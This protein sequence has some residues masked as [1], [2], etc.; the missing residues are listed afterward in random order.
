[1]RWPIF[2]VILGSCTHK[3]TKKLKGS[4]RNALFLEAT[5]SRTCFWSLVN[6]PGKLKVACV[7]TEERP[8]SDSKPQTIREKM[9]FG[10]LR[11]LMKRI[12]QKLRRIVLLHCGLVT[13]GFIV[14]KTGKSSFF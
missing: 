11:G 1:M 14:G 12:A 9:R 8:I 10:G 13:V 2:A 7:G 5:H 4:K 3:R 6:E